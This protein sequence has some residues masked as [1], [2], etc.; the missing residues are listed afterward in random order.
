MII[1]T[2]LLTL[3][4]WAS[5]NPDQ[6]IARIEIHSHKDIGFEFDPQILNQVFIITI[7]HPTFP[8]GLREQ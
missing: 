2:L 4:G 3:T 8:W 6:S 7:V 5:E 1:G